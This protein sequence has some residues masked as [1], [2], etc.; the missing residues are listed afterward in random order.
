MRA[1]VKTRKLFAVWPPSLM[2][3]KG[4]RLWV[5]L[6]HTLRTGILNM[7]ITVGGRLVCKIR[8]MSMCMCLS[9]LEYTVAMH[10]VTPIQLDFRLSV[11]YINDHIWYRWL[12]LISQNSWAMPN[13]L[14]NVFLQYNLEYTSYYISIWGTLLSSH[15]IMYSLLVD[16]QNS[17]GDSHSPN[18]KFLCLLCWNAVIG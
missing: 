11:A 9:A 4:K 13:N 1:T 8:K 17:G 14:A 5:G 12:S 16:I 2:G 10:C 3:Y 7:V 18:Y 6:D 15:P